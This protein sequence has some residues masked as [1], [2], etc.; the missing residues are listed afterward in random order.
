MNEENKTKIKQLAVDLRYHLEAT[1]GQKRDND[2]TEALTTL[3][4]TIVSTMAAA[5]DCETVAAL[6]SVL[7]AEY[8]NSC[9]G[10]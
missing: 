9:P 3:S 2:T 7:Q 6:F 1:K 8:R 10:V 5:G 4:S